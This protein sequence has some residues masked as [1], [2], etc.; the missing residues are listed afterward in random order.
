[1]KGGDIEARGLFKSVVF[2]CEKQILFCHIGLSNP[3]VQNNMSQK[4]L[5]CVAI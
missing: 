1:M 5:A 4:W 2:L 3:L